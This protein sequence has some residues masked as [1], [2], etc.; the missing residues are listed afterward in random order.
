MPYWL[1]KIR[2]M[3]FQAAFAGNLVIS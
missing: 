3:R 2:F 1:G